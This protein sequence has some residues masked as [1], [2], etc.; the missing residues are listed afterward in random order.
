LPPPILPPSRRDHKTE[1]GIIRGR[2]VF[3]RI[4]SQTSDKSEHNR[5]YG[6]PIGPDELKN[7]RL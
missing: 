5:L 4:I 3:V 2:I 7:H 6:K 1:C